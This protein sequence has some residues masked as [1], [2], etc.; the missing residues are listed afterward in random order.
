MVGMGD[1]ADS[2][3]AARQVD[4]ALGM[5]LARNGRAQRPG[6]AENQKMIELSGT[7]LFTGDK[8]NI[9]VPAFF[10]S[11]LCFQIAVVGQ[12]QKVDPVFAC[13]FDDLADGGPAIE[14][15]LRM[16]MYNSRIVV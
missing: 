11:L 16:K 15:I 4:Q 1:E 14:G 12:H 2:T 3:L 10:P 8:Q 7:D 9:S 6:V 13:R 5:T